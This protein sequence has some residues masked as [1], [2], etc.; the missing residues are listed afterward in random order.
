MKCANR[1]LIKS[2]KWRRQW[3]G[4]ERERERAQEIGL[5]SCE[6]AV[7]LRCSRLNRK[8][9][10]SVPQEDKCTLVHLL[11]HSAQAG[12]ITL[13]FSIILL[14]FSPLCTLN[15]CALVRLFKE[16]FFFTKLQLT[17]GTVIGKL[18]CLSKLWIVL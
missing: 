5:L 6:G 13:S 17:F 11:P 4:W 16:I 18:F 12:A 8:W 10:F 7:E 15:K 3:A 2:N 14:I 1:K 9:W